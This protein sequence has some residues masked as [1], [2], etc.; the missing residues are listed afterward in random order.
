VRERELY[1]VGTRVYVRYYAISIYITKY[2][3]HKDGRRSQS[4]HGVDVEK[5]ICE[6][7]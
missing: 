1:I 2:F 3:Y 4:Q 5:S 7:R 6:I